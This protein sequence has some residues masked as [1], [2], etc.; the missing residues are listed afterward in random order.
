MFIFKQQ[1]CVTLS[2]GNVV[3]GKHFKVFL[4]LQHPLDP[5]LYLG[6]TRFVPQHLSLLRF[7]PKYIIF[8]MIGQCR[9]FYLSDGP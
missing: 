9:F 5:Q 6:Q 4:A 7:F 3:E 2:A 8:P 1:V